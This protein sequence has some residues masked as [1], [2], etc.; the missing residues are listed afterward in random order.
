MFHLVFRR[1]Q[2]HYQPR[3]TCRQYIYSNSDC[4]MLFYYKRFRHMYLLSNKVADNP[5]GSI[6]YSEDHD[7]HNIDFQLLLT[8][9]LTKKQSNQMNID[10]IYTFY[11][12]LYFFI[13]HNEFKETY[14]CNSHKLCCN[15][16]P[17]IFWWLMLYCYFWLM[18]MFEHLGYLEYLMSK[19]KLLPN[20]RNL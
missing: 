11:I 15:C 17:S 16:T 8:M 14:Y 6:H 5:F 10:L 18:Q 19:V 9:N 7:L 20:L 2:I 13:I 4:W 1:M 3:T 12:N